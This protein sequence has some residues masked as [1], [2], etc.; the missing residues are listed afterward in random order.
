[1]FSKQ[2]IVASNSTVYA[3]AILTGGQ[4]STDEG[5]QLHLQNFRDGGKNALQVVEK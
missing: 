2:E 3:P 4:S 1:M 5:K